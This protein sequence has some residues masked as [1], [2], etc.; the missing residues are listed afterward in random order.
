M[1]A[2]RPTLV[3][4]LCGLLC[5]PQTAAQQPVPTQEQFF[6]IVREE[7]VAEA[8]ELFH[9]VRLRVPDAVIFAEYPMN[10]LGLRYLYGGRVEEA[11]ELLKLNVLAYPEAFNTYDSLAEAYMIHGDFEAAIENYEISVELEP[12]NIRGFRYIYLLQHYTKEEHYITMRDGVRLFTQVYIPKDRSKTY[13]I[14]LRRT[15]YSVGYYGPTYFHQRLGPNDLYPQEGFI[16]VYQDVR[17]TYMSEGDFVVM[18]PHK[19]DKRGPHDTDESSDTYDTI[20]WLL[21]NVP[22]NNGRVGIY[23]ISYP[24]F[25]AVMGMIDAHPALVASSPQASPAD[26]WTGDDFHHNGAFRLM[27]TFDWLVRSARQRTGPSTAGP[28]RFSYGTPDGYQFFLDLGVLSNVDAQYLHGRVPTWNEYMEHGDYDDYWKRQSVLPH[29]QDIE[30][31]VLHVAGWFDAE[32]FRGPMDIYYT[33]EANDPDNKST[34]VIGPWRHGGWASMD[35]DA[36]GE[37]NF[38]Q[39]TGEY[40]RENVEFPFF[41]YYLKDEGPLDLPEALVFET[42][43]N[44]WRSYDHWPPEEATKKSLYLHAGGGLSFE[45]PSGDASDAHDSYLSDLDK[46]VPWSAGIATRQGHLWMVEDQRFAARRPDVLVY[47]SDVL[48][49]DITIA[50]PVIANLFVSTTGTDADWIVKLIDVY[51]DGSWKRGVDSGMRM[52]GF[53]MLLAGEVFRSKYRNSFENPEPIIPNQVTEISFDLGD[54]CH[55]FLKDHRIMVQVQSTWFPVIDRNPQTFVDI[56]HATEEDYQDAEQ[57][58][59]RT[60]EFPSH[61]EVLVLERGR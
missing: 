39:R 35:G 42:G 38:V 8:V 31:G 33:M 7:G 26:M 11:I 59:F 28:T 27:Y 32:D 29:L 25:Q 17:G 19:P 22:N 51:P 52:G 56:Y 61:L 48:T 3:L 36:L 16:F 49:E 2:H 58:V 40:F 54:K 44:E 10:D 14:L 53:Q 37:I 21:E 30:L 57:R 60:R 18:R 1:R 15:P 24:G 12:D 9:S 4:L 47:Q 20:E 6:Q 55:T 45:S 46:P 5:A 43:S 34:I 13:P 23:G 41:N 50:G